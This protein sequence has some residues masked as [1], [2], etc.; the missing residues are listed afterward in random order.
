METQQRYNLSPNF[1]TEVCAE[2]QKCSNHTHLAPQTLSLLLCGLCTAWNQSLC[3]LHVTY[4]EVTDCIK[5]W[6]KKWV[7]PPIL[8]KC[9]LNSRL[10]L[11]LQ[12]QHPRF[13][14][15]ELWPGADAAHPKVPMLYSGDVFAFPGMLGGTQKPPWD[16]SL[17]DDKRQGWHPGC[18]Q[19]GWVRRTEGQEQSR[20][21][22]GEVDC[23]SPLAQL[24]ATVIFRHCSN[25]VTWK[26][27]WWWNL[28][29]K[30][31]AEINSILRL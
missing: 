2:S 22:S 1:H 17:L 26:H 23:A 27:T 25:T 14:P 11:S 18:P 8:K 21:V 28:L 20:A 4:P 31:G 24:K 10:R 12:W 15:P 5:K 30:E 9:W 7:I 19:G 29:T 6:D 3:W 16:T 13:Q